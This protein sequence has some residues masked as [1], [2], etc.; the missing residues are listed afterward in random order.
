MNPGWWQAEEGRKSLERVLLDLD[1]LRASPPKGQTA[2]FRDLCDVLNLLL[3]ASESCARSEDDKQAVHEL[4]FQLEHRLGTTT[5]VDRAAIEDLEHFEETAISSL[6]GKPETKLAIYGTLAP[7]EINHSQIAGIPGT[8]HDGFVRGDLQ[9]TGWGAEHGFPAL[10]WRPDGARVPT[11]LFV[12]PDLVRHWRR[13][14]DFEGVGYRRILVIVED[15][16]GILAVANLYADRS[17]SES[18]VTTS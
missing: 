10:G 8:W 4:R 5:F 13:L 9:H 16:S 3:E 18:N 11:K 1:A 2:Y 17:A 7:G 12:A 6:L 15:D 14:D